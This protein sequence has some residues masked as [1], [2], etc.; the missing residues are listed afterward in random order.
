MELK[1]QIR[2]ARKDKGYTQKEL[3]DLLDVAKTSISNWETSVSFPGIE[4]LKKLSKI[5][6][7][8]FKIK[9]YEN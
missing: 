1:Y 4:T 8:E 9:N 7:C 5:L 2:N 6:E 3:A